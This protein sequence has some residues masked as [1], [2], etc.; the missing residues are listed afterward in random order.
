[1]LNFIK[2]HLRYGFKSFLV[3][4]VGATQSLILQYFLTEYAGVHYILSAIIGI[5]L[6][7]LNNYFLNYYYSF[8]IQDLVKEV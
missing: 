5:G 2:K 4:S 6:S 8:K 7:F 3:G 1:M